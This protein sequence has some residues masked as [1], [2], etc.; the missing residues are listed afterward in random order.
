MKPPFDSTSI[1]DAR[2]LHVTDAPLVH[3]HPRA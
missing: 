2:D 3:P 1:D